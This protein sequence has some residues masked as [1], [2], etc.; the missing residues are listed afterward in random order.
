M[1]A[2]KEWFYFTSNLLSIFTFIMV[3]IIFFTGV[4]VAVQITVTLQKGQRIADRLLEYIKRAE[5]V[6]RKFGTQVRDKAVEANIPQKAR[7]AGQRTV[8]AARRVAEPV[9]RE[10]IAAPFNNTFNPNQY[11]VY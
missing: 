6:L 2:G 7:A 5:D 9:E 4:A 11:Q 1:A 3:A 8:S 10:D